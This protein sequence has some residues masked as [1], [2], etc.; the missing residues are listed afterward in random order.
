MTNSKTLVASSSEDLLA[1]VPYVLGFQP[2]ESAVMLTFGEVNFHARIDLPH[3]TEEVGGFVDALVEPVRRHGVTTVVLLAYTD[4]AVR[5]SW[6]MHELHDALDAHDVNVLDMMR[7]D[8]NLWYP[9][10]DGLPADQYFGVVFDP[11]AHRFAA[12]SVLEGRITHASR[13]ELADSL[14]GTDLEAVEAV[15]DAVMTAMRAWSGVQPTAERAWARRFVHGHVAGG[16]RASAEGV[17]R[18]VVALC[19]TRIR[20]ELWSQLTR[21]QAE[22]QVEFWTDVVR[23]T[24]LDCMAAPA[25]LL[26][27]AAWLSGNGAL[28]WCALDR[29]G[30]AE[31]DYEMAQVIGVFLQQAVPPSDWEALR[32]KVFEVY[33]EDA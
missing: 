30:L 6:A 4:D 15:E 31:P 22:A 7:V 25:A 2:E 33:D 27:C 10:R 24:P 19:D 11:R 13:E 18:L 21:E 26:A 9:I 12:E 16:T 17:G 8:G 14:V 3:H 1:M 5:A 20:N 29:A 28:S 23:R 32:H